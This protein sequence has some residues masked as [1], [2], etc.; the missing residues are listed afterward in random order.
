MPVISALRKLGRS[1]LS[2]RPSLG[3][4]VRPYLKK[5][6]NKKPGHQSYIFFRMPL[7][8]IKPSQV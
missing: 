5:T 1:L 2:S 6:N 8:D 3:Y 7:K 4:I